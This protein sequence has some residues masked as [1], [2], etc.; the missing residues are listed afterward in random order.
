[1]TVSTASIVCITIAMI[2]GLSVPILMAIFLPKK[3]GGTRKAFWIGCLVMFLFALTLESYLHQ[4]V[5][6]TK[7]GETIW[8]NVFL[9]AIY[10]GLMA[11][12]FEELGR[13]LAF[14]TV[15][16]RER[17]NDQNV[18]TYAAGH[19]GFEII[20]VLFFTMLNNLTYATVMRHP[21]KMEQVYEH[22]TAE[23]AEQIREV[24]EQLSVTPAW[25][26]LL[27][28]AERASG[29]MLQ[30]GFTIFVWFSAKKG[31]KKKYLLPVAILLHAFTDGSVVLFNEFTK[32]A[33]ATEIFVFLLA[34]GVDV[35]AWKL[36]KSEKT[37]E[38][39]A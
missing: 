17:E 20:A 2:I 13:Y 23:Q 3:T 15:L 22:A 32:N 34:I 11:G 19:G 8:N 33:I 4:Y 39:K 1:M 36:W 16:R 31:G 21:E 5:H 14:H 24:Y 12:L 18:L 6:D 28:I 26:Y 10:G 37:K 38:I 35:L 27:S 25:T 29:L 7:L 9:F 30:F